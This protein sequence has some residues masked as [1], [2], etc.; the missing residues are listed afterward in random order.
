MLNRV[1]WEKESQTVF[2]CYM[3]SDHGMLGV[4]DL[5]DLKGLQDACHCSRHILPA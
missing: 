1:T 5:A 2:S 3:N 4:G